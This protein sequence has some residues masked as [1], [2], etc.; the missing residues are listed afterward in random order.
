MHSK[1]PSRTAEL[2]YSSD[3]TLLLKPSPFWTAFKHYPGR[4]DLTTHPPSPKWEGR[5]MDKVAL[6]NCACAPKGAFS[7][8]TEE[9]LSLCSAFRHHCLYIPCRIKIEI[10][11]VHALPEDSHNLY[12]SLMITIPLPSTS[13]AALG[14]QMGL[15]RSSMSRL[16]RNCCIPRQ[17]CIALGVFLLIFISVWAGHILNWDLCKK[18]PQVC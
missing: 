12:T 1:T 14:W 13:E 2:A 7:D 18:S 5:R 8:L 3:F 4:R 17:K 15:D 11:L 10:T 9:H 6:Q 16:G